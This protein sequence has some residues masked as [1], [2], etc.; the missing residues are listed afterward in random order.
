MNP[1]LIIQTRQLHKQSTDTSG[2]QAAN[3]QERV[4]LHQQGY[5]QSSHF[6]LTAEEDAI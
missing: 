5:M 2:S 3:R 6:T 1:L 4:A